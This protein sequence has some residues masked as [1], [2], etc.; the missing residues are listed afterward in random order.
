[1]C[2]RWTGSH[3][4]H[5]ST[6]I[7]TSMHFLFYNYLLNSCKEYRP[8]CVKYISLNG[9]IQV[10]L[11]ESLY[12]CKLQNRQQANSPGASAAATPNSVAFW[13]FIYKLNIYFI[14]V[15]A[16]SEQWESFVSNANSTVCSGSCERTDR[17]HSSRLQTE[18]GISLSFLIL[19]WW[20]F[21]AFEIDLMRIYKWFYK[22]FWILV[23][24]SWKHFIK[25]VFS[26]FI[27]TKTNVVL[28]WHY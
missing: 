10:K 22:G 28:L 20:F 2:S 15:F 24:T 9:S 5:I 13:V 12:K 16:I 19:F 25:S 6:K 27:T 26:Y 3:F 14:S 11:A 1:M 23:F 7:W 18:L 21:C 4:L 8:E 17:S